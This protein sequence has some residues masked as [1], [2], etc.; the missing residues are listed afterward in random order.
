MF[1]RHQSMRLLFEH[2]ARTDASEPMVARLCLAATAMLGLEGASITVGASESVRTLICA[3]NEVARQLEDLQDD[4]GGGPAM[5]AYVTG[6]LV[7]ATGEE[8][9]SRW[10]V[11]ATEVEQRLGLRPYL[12]SVPMRPDLR[13]LGVL[14]LYAGS[15]A[16]G[17]TDPRTVQL[18]ADAIGIAVLKSWDD[19]ETSSAPWAAR[20]TI[21][22][23]SGMVVAQLGVGPTDALAVLRAHAFAIGATLENVA[24][25]VVR[26]EL[27]FTRDETIHGP[28]SSEEDQ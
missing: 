15:G 2:L 17:G 22:Q 16:A 8:T 24:A 27:N 23:A 10:P 21:Y 6:T 7:Q 20:D 18:V 9:A 4:L 1:E 26:R 14:S 28:Q 25:A 3:T 12:L 11:L 5:D 19:P 13:T